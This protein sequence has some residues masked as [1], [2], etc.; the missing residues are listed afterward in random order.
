M[1]QSKLTDKQIDVLYELSK[2]MGEDDDL[3]TWDDG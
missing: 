1:G 2:W 3:D